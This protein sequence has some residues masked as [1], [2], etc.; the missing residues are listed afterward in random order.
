QPFEGAT[1]RTSVLV[2]Q[3][4]QKT[5]YPVTYNLWKRA[6]PGRIPIDATLAEVRQ[7]TRIFRIYAKPIQATDAQ[8]APWISGRPKALKAVE[9]VIGPSEYRAWA[10][11]CTWA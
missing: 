2:V 7:R 8:D 1:N 6:K 10:G 11:C 5:S 4:D 9:R 3:R